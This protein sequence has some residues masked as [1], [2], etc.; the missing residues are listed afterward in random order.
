M[1]NGPEKG[2]KIEVSAARDECGHYDFGSFPVKLKKH[3][4][5][6]NRYWWSEYLKKRQEFE[7]WHAQLIKAAQKK[8]I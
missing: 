3:K 4:L 6:V 5:K 8:D 7:I 2:I 1:S